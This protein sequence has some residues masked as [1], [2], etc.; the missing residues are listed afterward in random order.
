MSRSE[1]A[2]R[3]VLHAGVELLHDAGV[4]A[5]TVEAVAKRSGVAKTTIY[6]H[7][8]G[9]SELLI[10]TLRSFIEPLPTPNTG[11]LRDDL[12]TLYSLIVPT[13]ADEITDAGR[14]MFG[15]LH[16]AADDPDLRSAL[17]DLFRERTGPI[18]TLLQLAQGRGEL[19]ADL[20][21][22]LAVDLVEGPFLFRFLIR[23]EPFTQS[24]FDALLDRVIAGLAHR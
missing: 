16:A 19:P 21:L 13:S 24:D 9:G 12:R 17:E 18:R 22:D 6:R 8:P 1:N 7:W 4:P 10:D 14:M 5:F 15:L 23:R 20:D 11:C 3:K 2:R